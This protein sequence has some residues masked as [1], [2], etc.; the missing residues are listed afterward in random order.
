MSKA[1]V[2]VGLTIL[3]AGKIFKSL[4]S[5][6]SEKHENSERYKC[7]SIEID[8]RKGGSVAKKDD[9]TIYTDNKET[10]VMIDKRK[11]GSVVV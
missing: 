9:T 11:D 2:L 1:R 7:K 4:S 10:T 6:Q 8:T 5:K 3:I